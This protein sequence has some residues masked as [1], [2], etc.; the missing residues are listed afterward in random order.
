MFLN[1]TGHQYKTASGVGGLI[2]HWTSRQRP[3]LS[4]PKIQSHLS[5]NGRSGSAL[6]KSSEVIIYHYQQVVGINTWRKACQFDRLPAGTNVYNVAQFIGDKVFG[7]SVIE[8]QISDTNCLFPLIYMNFSIKH[9][10][11]ISI[12]SFLYHHLFLAC[13]STYCIAL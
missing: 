3:S 13:E 5:E 12:F 4:V 6:G 7:L 2:F 1:K 9:V 11:G 10:M 8:M